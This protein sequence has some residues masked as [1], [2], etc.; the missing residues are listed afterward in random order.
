[1]PVVMFG[2]RR[3]DAVF[4]EPASARLPAPV[5]Q[6]NSGRPARPAASARQDKSRHCVRGDRRQNQTA[7]ER[8]TGGGETAVPS[9]LTVALECSRRSA[10]RRCVERDRT[11]ERTTPPPVRPVPALMVWNC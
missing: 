2:S 4:N 10:P 5:P 11:A 3:A 1:V 9:R 8:Q 7:A 6:K